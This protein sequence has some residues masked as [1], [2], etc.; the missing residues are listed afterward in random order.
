MRVATVC[1]ASG[2]IKTSFIIVGMTPVL[3]LSCFRFIGNV[4]SFIFWI[5][6]RSSSSVVK[7]GGP[8]K[9]AHRIGFG[10]FSS[11]LAAYF[12]G[13]GFLAALSS[14]FF[15]LGISLPK[16]TLMGALGSL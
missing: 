13:G 6:L 12:L 15:S 5:A 4:L 8:L 11:F 7:G 14:F 16:V 1:G 3:Q 9:G 10:G 2:G